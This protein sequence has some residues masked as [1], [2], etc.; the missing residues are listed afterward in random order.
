MHRTTSSFLPFL[1]FL[2]FAGAC[3]E[4]NR[5]A[6]DTAAASDLVAAANPVIAR[7]S[8]EGVDSAVFDLHVDGTFPG[9]ASAE[10]EVSEIHLVHPRV[11]HGVQGHGKITIVVA[12]VVDDDTCDV[13]PHAKSFRVRLDATSATTSDPRAV[14]QVSPRMESDYDVFV[15]GT[16]LGSLHVGLPYLMGFDPVGR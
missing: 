3:S 12:D 16:R 1:S 2:F 4:P 15:N 6:D 13:T 14:H 10:P 5:P 8:L 11:V 7:G 9:C